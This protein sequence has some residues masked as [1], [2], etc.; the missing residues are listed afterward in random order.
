MFYSG[1]MF[2]KWQGSAFATGLVSRALHRIEIHG[3]TIRILAPDKFEQL[4]IA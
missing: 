1:A 2:P 3:A 4:A